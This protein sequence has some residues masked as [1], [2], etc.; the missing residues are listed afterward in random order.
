M[1]W[2]SEVAVVGSRLRSMTSLALVV[3]KVSITRYDF[4]LE[5]VLSQIEKLLA[6]TKVMNATALSLGLS[7]HSGH[8]CDVE[9][10]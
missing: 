3:R 5:E 6:N 2:F 8:C 9:A 10:S 4:P 1:C 7:C